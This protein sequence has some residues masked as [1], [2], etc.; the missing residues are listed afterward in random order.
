VLAVSK[1][2]L[3]RRDGDAAEVHRQLAVATDVLGD[4][5][6]QAYLRAGTHDLLGYLAEDLD[7][8]RAHRAAACAAAA[9]AGIAPLTA[10]VLV[11]VADL[12]LRRDQYEQVAR[13]LA[14]SAAVQGL[15][16]RS[17][18][19]LPR[20]ERAARNRL[21]D[22]KFAEAAREGAETS[23]TELVAVTLAS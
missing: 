23:W 10:Q 5:A 1:A 9:E 16:D 11:G 21:G 2:E 13:L 14:A 19:D 6:G 22:T 3:A 17:H 12:A 7:E 18:P 8:A 4:E 15:R 20:I